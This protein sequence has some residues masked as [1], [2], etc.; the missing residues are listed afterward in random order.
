MLI[1][2]SRICDGVQNFF[3]QLHELDVICMY[4]ELGQLMSLLCDL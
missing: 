4:I 3:C 1:L 2:F